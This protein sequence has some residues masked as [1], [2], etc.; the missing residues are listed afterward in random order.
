MLKKI[1][2]TFDSAIN[3]AKIRSVTTKDDKARKAYCNA[4]KVLEAT[5][6]VVM[7]TL[8]EGGTPY[9]DDAKN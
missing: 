8:I 1:E 9:S 7:Q 4:L 6:D 5:K 2:K 3:V